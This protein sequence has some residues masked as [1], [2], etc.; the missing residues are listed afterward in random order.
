MINLI[1]KVGEDY[2]LSEEIMETIDENIFNNLNNLEI[3][4]RAHLE[5]EIS[6]ILYI[7]R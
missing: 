5:K 4:D 2:D 6:D 1:K 3:R 7:N